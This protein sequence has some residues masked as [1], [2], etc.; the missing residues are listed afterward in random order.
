VP[1]T[2]DDR[3]GRARIA[4]LG[5]HHLRGRD[6][7]P[8]L[9]WQLARAAAEADHIVFSGDLLDR[10]DR[11]LL[12]DARARL[13][14]RGLLN[15]DRLTIIHGNHDLASS[16]GWPRRRADILRMVFRFWDPPPLLARRRERFTDLFSPVSAPL[17]YEK[18]IAGGQW[19][20][21]AIDS[22][23][24]PWAPFTYGSRA[25]RLRT[26]LGAVRL[27]DLEWVES[28]PAF[29]S[30]LVMH[31]YPLPTPALL[32]NEGRV[33]VPMHVRGPVDRLLAALGRAGVRLIMCGHVHRT[34]LDW[35]DG[36]AVGLQGQSG[37]EWASRPLTIYDVDET[38]VRSEVIGF[39]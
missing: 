14:A 22:T 15:P 27:S 35:H 4:H 31:H 16:G 8:V 23:P 10:W 30:V 38:S 12:L 25:L 17:P 13:E 37:A 18:R 3:R 1:S 6:E 20:L 9:E 19:R 26:A 24:F 21:L 5:D 11:N 28:L 34:Q 2:R 36:I 33:V 32:W 7:L 29:P 39:G